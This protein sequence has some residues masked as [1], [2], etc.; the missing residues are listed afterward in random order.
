MNVWTIFFLQNYVIANQKPNPIIKIRIDFR[1]LHI[2]P[3]TKTTVE[4]GTQSEC[5]D[6]FVS[7]N[8]IKLC[9]TNENQHSKYYYVYYNLHFIQIRIF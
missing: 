7:I 3:P 2:A 1:I 8:N 5:K 9:G 4:F 6:E